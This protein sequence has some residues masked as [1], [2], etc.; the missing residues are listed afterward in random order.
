MDTQGGHGSRTG[1][2]ATAG[3]DTQGGHGSRAGGEAMAIMDTQG[4]HGSR[5]GGVATAGMDTCGVLRLDRR[6]LLEAR[7]RRHRLAARALGPISSAQR[8]DL[9]DDE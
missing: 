8:T 4:G 9:L 6:A 7:E 5:T 1:G 3:P 2:V